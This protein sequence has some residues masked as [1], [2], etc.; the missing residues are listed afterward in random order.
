MIWQPDVLEKKSKGILHSVHKHLF[1]LIFFV[2][3][4]HI[5]FYSNIIA[6]IGRF[7]IDHRHFGESMRPRKRVGTF[8]MDVFC[9]A[10]NADYSHGPNL[11]PSKCFLTSDA[12]VSIF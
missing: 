10:S 11:K 5:F 7:H 1:P 4:F 12:V 2:I 3:L 6:R 9:E 8:I